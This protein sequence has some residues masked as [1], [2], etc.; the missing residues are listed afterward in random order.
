MVERFNPEKFRHGLASTL[1]NVGRATRDASSKVISQT[2][3]GRDALAEVVEDLI[4]SD[5]ESYEEVV[6]AYNSAFTAMNDKGLAVLRQRERSADLLELVELLVNSIANTPKSFETAFEVID[7]SR[8]AFL[9]AEEF[10]RMDLEAAR[11]SALG[12]GAGLT[13]GAAVAS[14]APTAAMWVATTFGAASTG[15]AISTLSGAAATNAALAWLGGGAIAAGGGG[16]AVGGAL[17]ALAGPIGWTVAGAALLTSVVLFTKKKFETRETKQKALLALKKNTATVEGLDA[18]IEELLQQSTSLRE[19]LL[20]HFTKSQALFARDFLGLTT[21]QQS[22][23]AVLVNT[24]A[25]CANVLTKRV[26]PAVI[27][28]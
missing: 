21:E 25:A 10:A 11:A 5:A 17:L 27:D 16:T 23:L 26:N 2:M 15:T 24:A 4:D 18:Q 8:A 7:L 20:N 14:L 1:D 28:E 12:A 9:D 6:V 3:H 19:L 13:A 22:Q